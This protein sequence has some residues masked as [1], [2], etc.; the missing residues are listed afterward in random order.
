MKRRQTAVVGQRECLACHV[1]YGGAK[2]SLVK[3]KLSAGTTIVLQIGTPVQ[4]NVLRRR[5][6]IHFIRKYFSLVEPED[7]L[8]FHRFLCQIIPVLTYTIS[9]RNGKLNSPS[10]IRD[11][12]GKS[13][14][15]RCVRERIQTYGDSCNAY[16]GPSGLEFSVGWGFSGFSSISR[17]KWIIIMCWVH[18]TNG[19]KDS[20]LPVMPY[21]MLKRKAFP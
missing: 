12:Q 20:S 9:S 8:S 19:R 10:L 14:R 4:V 18:N 11:K 1:A 21:F 2:W 6:I 3:M 7:S 15:T 5:L 16:L 13:V 17:D